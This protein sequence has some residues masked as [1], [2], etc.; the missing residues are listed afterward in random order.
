MLT[1]SARTVADAV[2]LRERFRAQVRDRTAV[3][4]NVTLGHVL[5]EWLAGHQVEPTTRDTYATL[6]ATHIKPVLG[7]YTMTKLA[8]LGARPDETALWRVGRSPVIAAYV[9]ARLED[10]RPGSRGWDK[11]C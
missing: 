5:D 2:E 7:D 8:R 11:F 3:R 6:A 10:S 4:T 9:R 1:G